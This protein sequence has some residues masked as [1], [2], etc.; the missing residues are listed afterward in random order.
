MEMHFNFALDNEAL[1]IE[2]MHADIQ[3][4][5][6]TVGLKAEGYAKKN[7]TAKR[8]V[9]TGRLRNSISHQNDSDTVYVGT[10]VE[11]APYIEMGTSKMAARPYLGPSITEHANEYKEIIETALK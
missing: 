6:K 8:A 2:A 7:L 11:Y 9:D 10:N 5:L 1:I 3:K 4:G